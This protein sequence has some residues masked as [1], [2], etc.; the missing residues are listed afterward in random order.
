MW[1][2]PTG[3]Q[4]KIVHLVGLGP[5][6]HD[7]DQGWLTPHT[8]EVLWKADETW[9]INRG[10]FNIQHDLVWVMDH[11]TG[12]AQTYPHYGARL[13]N[14]D[15]PIITSDNLDGWPPHVHAYPFDAIWTWLNTE[16]NPPPVHIDWW[17]NSV[18]YIVVYAAFIG[19]KQ[20]NGWGLDY[21]HH[22]SGRVEDGHPN[23]AYWIA[24]MERVG[25]RCNGVDGSTFL[26]SNNRGFIY[27]YQ[28]DPRP[29]AVAQ[30]QRFRTLSGIEVP[31][32]GLA[33][34]SH[35]ENAP[36]R[37][38][39]PAGGEIVSRPAAGKGRAKKRARG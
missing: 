37:P 27:G 10:V 24:Q 33:P 31:A 22:R 11:I 34:P 39:A 6:H 25:L 8:P 23:V 3:R 36:L 14:H 30:R 9:T 13:W 26:D 28:A 7:F 20:I 17:V 32:E 4:P 2:H 16:F 1:R 19:V 35:P 12:E 18:P 38:A 5:T 21:H 15:R 29:A